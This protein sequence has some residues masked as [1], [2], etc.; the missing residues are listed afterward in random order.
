MQRSLQEMATDGA[1][2][3]S[4]AVRLNGQLAWEGSAGYADRDTTAFLQPAARFCVYSIT[5]SFTAAAFLRMQSRHRGL[6]LDESIHRWFPDIA[7]DSA[8]TLRHLF[9]HTSGIRD[10]GSSQKYYE[11][12]RSRPGEP[13]TEEEF[14]AD[15]RERGLLFAP[16]VKWAYSN[17]G[18]LLLKRVL[19]MESGSSLKEC[20]TTYVFEPLGHS[21][22]FIAEVPAD[23]ASCVPGYGREF[24]DGRLSDVRMV[25]HPG[26]CAPGVAVSTAGEVTAFFT[27]LFQGSF[28]DDDA[29]TDLTDLVRVPGNH[30]PAIEPSYGL[31]LIADPQGTFGPSFGHGGEGPG[32]SLSATVLPEHRA[33]CLSAAVFRNGSHGLNGGKSLHALLPGILAALE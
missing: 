4:C 22:S 2:G 5:K 13:W 6:R 26:W 16:G 20:L 7:P 18:Y 23:W 19:E 25:Y 17:V 27:A 31:G 15:T 8:I 21:E 1:P 9:Q 14:L 12:V 32:Y 11:A 10:Y 30:P 28:L 24:S 3:I 33:G 29:R